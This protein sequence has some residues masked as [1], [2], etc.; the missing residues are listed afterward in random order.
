ME[1]DMSYQ[2]EEQ[3]S[4]RDWDSS[5]IS[6]TPSLSSTTFCS[7][8]TSTFLSG[9]DNYRCTTPA[10]PSSLEEPCTVIQAAVL[11]PREFSWDYESTSVLE[12]PPWGVSIPGDSTE[13]ILTYYYL[14]F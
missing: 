11:F 2:N 9:E 12:I 4:N 10:F 3:V 5:S 8:S 7:K 14:P 13:G 1:D 6:I